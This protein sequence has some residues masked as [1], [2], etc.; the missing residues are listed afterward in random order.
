VLGSMGRGEI[1]PP[2]ESSASS[3]GVLGCA[4]PPSRV[5]KYGGRPGGIVE[6]RS[7]PPDRGGGARAGGGVW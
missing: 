1:G 4:G 3:D 5:K 6:I 7:L 2:P